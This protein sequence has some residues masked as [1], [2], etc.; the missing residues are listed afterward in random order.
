MVIIE[1]SIEPT[2][3]IIPFNSEILKALNNW[4][5]YDDT[6]HVITVISNF[7][8]FKRRWQLMKE[9]I[10]KMKNFENIQLYVVELAYGNQNFH[11]TDKNNKNHLQL[12]TK[13]PLW[14]KENMINIGV[15]KLLP[16]NWKA[17]AWIDGDIEFDNPNWVIDTLKVLTKCDLVQ[18]F[19]TCLDLDEKE[20]PFSIWQSYGYKY[21]HGNSSY[22]K[23]KG[24]NYWHCGYAWACRR[25]FF[26]KMGGL[27]ENS[28]LGSGD[29]IMT[30]GY[31]GLNSSVHGDLVGFDE[32]IKRYN[33]NLDNI[34][35]GYIPTNIKHFFHGSK[36]NR[37]YIERN[38]IYVNHKFDPNIHI[39]K[40]KNGVIIPTKKMTKQFL[41]DIEDYFRVRNEDE[42]FYL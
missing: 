42:F 1:S 14:H 21:A 2:K 37:R 9:F 5:I 35:I 7:C 13:Y 39:T 8:E 30:Q 36:E 33:K 32:D 31:L 16:K 19:T 17:V 26:D 41:K 4:E 27:Y 34:K 15:K 6:L 20:I 24:I 12:R 11:I 38:D 25:D 28:I 40:D 10:E 22:H 29:Y 23:D 3:K 18:L